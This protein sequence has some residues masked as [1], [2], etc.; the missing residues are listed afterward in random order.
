[1]N[2]YVLINSDNASFYREDFIKLYQKCF[3]EEPYFETWNYDD[4]LEIWD[5][6]I[7]KGIIIVCVSKQNVIGF[8]LGHKANNDATSDVSEMLTQLGNMKLDIELDKTIYIS[9]LAVSSDHRRCGIA[10]ELVNNLFTEAK[11]LNLSTYLMRSDLKNSKSSPLF[12][13]YFNGQQLDICLNNSLHEELAN[14]ASLQKGMWWG[15]I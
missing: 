2:N 1:M 10:K 5:S 7:Q 15:P 11:K 8:I 3:S 13:K 9:E 6:H 12:I 14:S 4:V